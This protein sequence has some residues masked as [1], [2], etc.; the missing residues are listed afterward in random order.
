MSEAGTQMSPVATPVPVTITNGIPSPD[1]VSMSNGGQLQF[2]NA[3][4]T[5]YML[6]F[7]SKGNDKHAAVSV[8]I[9]ANGTVT[10]QANPGTGDQNTTCRYNVLTLAGNPTDPTEGGS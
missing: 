6:E 3:D 1:P 5:P 2:T 4:N 8:V 9:Q 7:W 10:V